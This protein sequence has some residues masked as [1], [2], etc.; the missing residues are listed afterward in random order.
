MVHLKCLPQ[1]ESLNLMNTKVTDA[2]LVHLK[3][4]T[5]LRYLNLFGTKVSDSGMMEIRS[6][7]PKCDVR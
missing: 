1:L 2:A 5:K 3:G 6:A 7:L 4:L